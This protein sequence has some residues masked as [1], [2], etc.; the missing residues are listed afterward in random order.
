MSFLVVICFTFS[1]S[2]N[3]EILFV[4]M[5]LRSLWWLFRRA[6]SCVRLL[7]AFLSTR[8]NSTGGDR[9]RLVASKHWLELCNIELRLWHHGRW[10]SRAAWQ[11]DWLWRW[12]QVFVWIESTD[13]CN[14]GNVRYLNHC[15]LLAKI[16]A[17]ILIGRKVLRVCIIA[18]IIN[19]I[20]AVASW[21]VAVIIILILV[22]VS[23]FLEFFGHGWQG[24]T[25]GK[26]GQRIDEASL[27][28]VVMVKRAALAELAF[29][30][31]LPEL[32]RNGLVVRMHCAQRCLAEILW[33]WLKSKNN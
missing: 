1:I 26:I 25:F 28:I 22:I 20:V 27:L 8:L 10:C 31:L 12:R 30:G 15:V 14:V 33:K 16:V 29:T 23:S 19:G 11:R 9:K 2:C 13:S 24:D 18:S 32:A 5:V 6:D 21:I 4:V 3:C 17:H 7:N